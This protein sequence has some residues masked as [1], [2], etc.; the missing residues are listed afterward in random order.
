MKHMACRR[1]ST[2]PLAW[3][4]LSDLSPWAWSAFLSGEDFFF[5]QRAWALSSGASS[6]SGTDQKPLLI[7]GVLFPSTWTNHP[8]G[9]HPTLYFPFS[10]S[11]ECSNAIQ[12]AFA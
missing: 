9:S 1:R 12:A 7:A 4:S 5:F 3:S 6:G 10:V 11:L 8:K 2:I